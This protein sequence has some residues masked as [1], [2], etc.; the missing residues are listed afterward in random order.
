[1]SLLHILHHP[2]ILILKTKPRKRTGRDK[3]EDAAPMSSSPLDSEGHYGVPKARWGR[4]APRLDSF[5]P[6]FRDLQQASG[7]YAIPY[8]TTND[9]QPLDRNNYRLGERVHLSHL[10]TIASEVPYCS[11]INSS[12]QRKYKWLLKSRENEP[13]LLI[14][15]TYILEK[16]TPHLKLLT[17]F[18][19]YYPLLVSFSKTAML[20]LCIW[21]GTFRKIGL[22]I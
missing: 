10:H 22:T 17:I 1:M 21:I 6:I 8:T 4:A 3:S 7:Q 13:K 2:G 11:K 14:L 12:L 15:W 20:K 9:V 18:H 5:F 19:F 16:N